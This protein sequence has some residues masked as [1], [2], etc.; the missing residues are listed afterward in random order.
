M[1]EIASGLRRNEEFAFVSE[2][3]RFSV[4]KKGAY[5]EVTDYLVRNRDFHRQFSQTHSDS[6]FQEATQKK[7]VDYDLKAFHKG[8]VFPF[9]ITYRDNPNKILG[10][11]SFF[12]TAYAGMMNCACGY[13]LDKDEIGKG[14]MTEALKVCCEFMVKELHMHR[15]EAFILPKN[16][17]SLSVVKRVGFEYEGRRVS[18]MH[19]NGKYRD[20]EAFYILE[21]KFSM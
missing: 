12:N 13:H 5:K 10:R 6:Y 7:Y 2:R 9:W 20:H 21:D 8:D 11:V 15:I 14:I 18:Y 1:Y 17:K 19:I 16:E 4:L 3:L